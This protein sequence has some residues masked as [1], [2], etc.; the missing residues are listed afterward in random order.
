MKE[1]KPP[2]PAA[3]RKQRE[4]KLKHRGLGVLPVPSDLCLV[5]DFLE[6]RKVPE[7]KEDKDNPRKYRQKVGFALGK[8]LPELLREALKK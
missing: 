5:V 7:P 2:S 3:L 1:R 6:S 4:R 8:L